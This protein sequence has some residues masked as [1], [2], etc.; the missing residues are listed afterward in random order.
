[1]I[2]R[3]KE[4]LSLGMIM[5]VLLSGCTSGGDGGGYY[6]HPPRPKVVHYKN[7][8]QLVLGNFGASLSRYAHLKYSAYNNINIEVYE[9]LNKTAD[10]KLPISSQGMLLNSVGRLTETSG[11]FFPLKH[12]MADIGTIVTVDDSVKY[13]EVPRILQLQGSIDR[14]DIIYSDTTD[15]S[16][17]GTGTYR[18]QGGD[19]SFSRDKSNNIREISLS[20]RFINKQKGTGFNTYSRYGYASNTIRIAKKTHNRGFGVFLL[21]NGVTG[22]ESKTV[23]SGVHQAI[24]I[25]IQHTVIQ[26][27]GR[28]FEVPYWHCGDMFQ[29]DEVQKNNMRIDWGRKSEDAKIKAIQLVLN[30][31]GFSIPIGSREELVLKKTE[32]SLIA[33]KQH[34]GIDGTIQDFNYYFNLYNNMPFAG[35]VPK[36]YETLKVAITNINNGKLPIYVEPVRPLPKPPVPREMESSSIVIH[37]DG[38]TSTIIHPKVPKPT[39][40][41][42]LIPTPNPILDI[43]NPQQ[44]AIDE[45]EALLFKPN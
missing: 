43:R 4:V 26:A 24:N 29:V 17:E 32:L 12:I 39:S 10:D 19:L 15:S 13:T 44:R 1:M 5:G 35:F 3:G 30:M 33:I 38:T 41:P 9:I 31:Y 21:G 40:R 28:N 18:G 42:T 23:T 2:K 16:V 14:S 37:S 6:P 27:F 8:Y 7:K 25:L 20:L 36:N 34:L 22:N 45:E 11:N